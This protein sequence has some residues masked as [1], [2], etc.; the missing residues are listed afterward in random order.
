MVLGYFGKTPVSPDPEVVKFAQEQL[1]LE[2][3]TESPMAINDRNPKKGYAASQ[4]MI[5][6][7]GLPVTDE[8]VFIAACCAEKGI[9]FLQGKGTVG[10]RKEAPVAAV[11]PQA[12]AAPIAKSD[13]YTIALNGKSYSVKIDGNQAIVNGQGYSFEAKTGTAVEQA[14]VSSGAG[15]SVTTP[16][17][18]LILRIEKKNGD[19]VKEGETIMVIES[20]K[21]ETP[22]NAPAAGRITAIKV[23]AQQQIEA[24]TIVAVVG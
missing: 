7:A 19:M 8:N 15:Q 6:A 16:L 20:M 2:P 17:P 10:V 12:V 4:K 14:P 1:K 23:Q 3:T 13:S 21:M 9:A 22:L 24:G 18:G 5:E 11:K